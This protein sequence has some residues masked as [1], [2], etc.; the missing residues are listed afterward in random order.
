MPPIEAPA[1]VRARGLRC[2]AAALVAGAALLARGL[3]PGTPGT[4]AELALIAGFVVLAAVDWWRLRQ[5][6]IDAAAPTQRACLAG[7]VGCVVLF[8][9]AGSIGD[10]GLVGAVG[11]W[12]P[13]A[14]VVASPAAAT[15]W[16]T[17]RQ[18]AAG[19]TATEP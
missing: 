1:T 11:Y 5:Q 12:V 17:L 2:L 13:A 6:R 15:G 9:A 18:V 10:P 16:W 3:V 14:V 7:Q 4:A 19:P 8:A